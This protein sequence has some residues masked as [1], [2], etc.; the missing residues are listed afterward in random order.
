MKDKRETS[1]NER[2]S[3]DDLL[4]AEKQTM[5]A[6]TTALIE[7]SNKS[8]RKE[9]LKNYSE[10]AEDQFKVFSLMEERGFY[11]ISP[12]ERETIKTQ[13]ETFKKYLD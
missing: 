9:I 2:D 12:A 13:A 4:M 7:G 1:L 10:C 6:Y 8:V 5:W 3:L 11:K